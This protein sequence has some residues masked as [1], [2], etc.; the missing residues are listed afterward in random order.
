MD[1]IFAVDAIL[2]IWRE[3]EYLSFCKS[4]KLSCRGLIT[5]V[6]MEIFLGGGATLCI[7]CK[8]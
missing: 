5:Y 6:F 7:L 3:R 1:V 4:W 8:V 2:E